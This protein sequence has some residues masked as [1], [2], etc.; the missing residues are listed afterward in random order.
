MRKFL[1]A[2]CALL[3]LA[4]CLSVAFGDPDP[5]RP[6]PAS[7]NPV[8]FEK[9]AEGGAVVIVRDGVAAAT[10]VVPSSGVPLDAK[11]AKLGTVEELAAKEFVEHVRLATGA[12]LKIVADDRPLPEGNVVLI[13]AGRFTKEKNVSASD[14]PLE[15][16]RVATF[17][18]G[19]AIVGRVPDREKEAWA[20]GN[21][22][23]G[24]V[25]GT[26]D[27]L[28]RFLGVR[29]YYPGD[30]GRVVPRTT[31]LIVEPVAYS[32]YP[33]KIKRTMWPWK[34]FGSETAFFRK[35]EQVV[36]LSNL[37]YDLHKY[38]FREG[39]STPVSTACHTPP[40]FGIHFEK[41]P[42]CFELRAD[43]SRAPNFPCYGNPRTVELM[44]EDY[45]N[46]YE[47]DDRR[48]WIR[49]DKSPWGL[50]TER[51]L[52]VSPP[53]KGVE[54]KCEMCV[55]LIDT[56]TRHLGRTSLLLAT[57]TKNLAER[58]RELWPEKTVF[59][60]PYSNYT[61]PPKDFKMPGNV[62]A[63]ICMMRGAANV[64]ESEVLEDHIKMI[65]GWSAITGRRVQLWEY[66]CWPADCTALPFQYPRLIRE[67]HRKV[68]A[69]VE[70]VFINGGAGPPELPG[71]QWA[72][73][74][75]TIYC[76]FR[77]LWNPEFDV[78]AA[79]NEYVD[80]MYGA[81]SRPM[82]RIF[83]ILAKRWEETKWKDG[84]NGH[85]I[86]PS[87]VNDETMPRAN[88]LELKALLAEARK[89]AGDD[90]VTQRRV[91][92]FG[93]ALDLF[94]AESDRYHD[95]AG[96]PLLSILKVGDDPTIDG[97]LDEPCWKDAETQHFMNAIDQKNPTPAP[98]YA[99]AVQAVWTDSG[100]TFG[101]SMMEP[102]MDKL[103]ANF[104]IRDQAVYAEDAIEIF[105]DVEGG[106]QQYHHIVSNA[107]GTIYDGT[108]DMGAKWNGEGI[109]AVG[110]RHK[111]RW[112]LEVFIPY[113]ALTK[114][115]RPKTGTVWF[116]NL[117]RTLKAGQSKE[118]VLQ[119]WS[120]LFRGSN[121]DFNAFGRMR[122]VE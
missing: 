19:I 77:V 122:F 2:L 36:R 11:N 43:N 38:R 102:N 108:S 51:T 53:D 109:K 33:R 28:E 113:A 4:V 91:D 107:L 13:G 82:G 88:T 6:A 104:T 52:H 50:P 20:F 58:V 96:L 95:G 21:G 83:E 85:R 12:E 81:A 8:V 66:L 114:E 55:K 99:T 112:T 87:Q 30:D 39:S 84:V 57:F 22:H 92:F 7:L 117:T 40:S 31:A 111:D 98:E 97:K 65:A 86:T 79:M 25:N 18:G 49:G 94:F 116:G 62:L 70:G 78:D 37:D 45:R 101:F 24:V 63:M 60:L 42:E 46:F 74:H 90:N 54:C 121:H 15:G 41:H 120:T 16:F 9:A 47:K 75:P 103:R 76:W 48:P 61:D 26:Y 5:Q 68:D 119:R 44:I 35:R 118:W 64:K 56:E 100:V 110:Q 10:V 73:Q 115:V 72:Y 17:D 3:P 93:N 105:L 89:L 106:R 71:N 67:F 32:D 59:Y 1:P 29:W 23:R 27:F 34:T 80:L 69:Q 14:L